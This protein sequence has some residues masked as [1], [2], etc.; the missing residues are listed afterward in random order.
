M[1]G[2]LSLTHALHG[3]TVGLAPVGSKILPFL[4]CHPPALPGTPFN[5]MRGTAT[6]HRQGSPDGALVTFSTPR[7]LSLHSLIAWLILPSTELRWPYRCVGA[8]SVTRGL[9]I[10]GLSWWVAL[11]SYSATQTDPV[12]SSKTDPSCS[13]EMC[14]ASRCCPARRSPSQHLFT[15]TSRV[16]V[17]SRLWPSEAVCGR[18]WPCVAVCGR[19]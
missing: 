19:M 5:S 7:R 1:G 10:W 8:V 17:C 12:L 14:S 15:F 9:P 6:R 13:T 11:V 3:L 16:A 18:V 4:P 2:L